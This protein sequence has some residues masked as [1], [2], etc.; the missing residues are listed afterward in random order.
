LGEIEEAAV[1]LI[2][3][4]EP[5]MNPMDN[6]NLLAGKA[7]VDVLNISDENTDRGD[8]IKTILD[9]LASLVSTVR[10]AIFMAPSLAPVKTGRP[11]GVLRS[12]TALTQFIVR[13]EASAL[14]AGGDWTLNK[15]E[16][17]G[18]LIDA[19]EELRRYLPKQFLPAQGTHPYSPYQKIL[20]RSRSKF[21]LQHLG[22]K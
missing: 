5:L 11:P 2:R 17:K 10:L 20:S 14:I 21:P 13:L 22:Q 6:L 1:E 16:G 7:L 8:Q 4:I 18:T 9:D 19:L 12:G 15:N 3:K